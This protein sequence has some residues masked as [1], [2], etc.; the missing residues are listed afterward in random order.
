M[1]K[2]SKDIFEGGIAV[3]VDRAPFGSRIIAHANAVA[4]AL[5]A[6]AIVLHVL[7]PKA[8]FGGL[9]DPIEWERL[10]ETRANQV[11][12]HVERPT[13]DENPFL[14]RPQGSSRM[15]TE[16]LEGEPA[17]QICRWVDDRGADLIVI[18]ASET[19]TD[20][21]L[22]LGA[23]ARE[24]LDRAPGSLLLV[25]HSDDQEDRVIYRRIMVT[26]D[27]S[28]RAETALQAA[29]QLAE[30][31]DSELLLVH[32]VASPEMTGEGPLE[33]EDIELCE[34]IVRR[35]E[36]AAM[37]YLDRIKT[38]I[39]SKGL[40]VRTLVVRDDDV[41][42]CLLRL[43]KRERVDLM[44]LSAEGHGGRSEPFQGSV[45]SHLIA[46]LPAPALVV[47]SKGIPRMNPL[48]VPRHSVI[49]LPDRALQ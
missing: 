4:G 6:P 10:R 11:R 31:H 8:A 17:E 18:G 49:R 20:Q 24:L 16:L 45:V 21:P 36:K 41:R 48:S 39:S 46:H 9:P 14:N 42:G 15:E 1:S 29:T 43:A 40:M 37:T 35:N 44:V 13:R 5:A 3:C 26:L 2:P 28:S 30:A 25:P 47:K 23:T 27:G 7:E 38:R 34:R 19:R 12:E 32:V 22:H 33:P